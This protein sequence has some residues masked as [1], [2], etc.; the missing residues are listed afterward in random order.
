M[1][2]DQGPYTFVLVSWL[3]RTVYCIN[4]ASTVPME[5]TADFE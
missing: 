3:S 5:R 1:Q 2:N 4:E